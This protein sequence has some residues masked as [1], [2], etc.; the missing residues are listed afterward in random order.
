MF[1][2]LD[3]PLGIQM[4]EGDFGEVLP[5]NITEGEILEGD[6]LRFI[7]QDGAHNDMINKVVDVSNNSFGFKLTEEETKLLK[8]GT[9]KWGL[10]QYRDNLL[11]D[12]LTANNK[13]KVI[14]GQ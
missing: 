7:I 3:E 10:K 9:Y 14:R 12:T 11:I 1:I 4:Y 13:F 8:E 2:E 5:I 6:V